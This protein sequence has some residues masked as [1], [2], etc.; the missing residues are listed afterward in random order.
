MAW[1]KS[2]RA[3]RQ[4]L[5]LVSDRLTIRSGSRSRCLR[6]AR[7][8]ATAI[9][10]FVVF[11]PIASTP[12]DDP[13][14][15]LLCHQYRGL[16]RYDRL[17]DRVHLFFADPDL[18]TGR[19]GPHARLACTDCHARRE[20]SV[21]PHLAVTPVDCA[22]Q[23]HLSGPARLAREFSH[24]NIV[25]ML[26]GSSH[27]PD[28]LAAIQ[29]EGG[30]VLSEGQSICLYCHDEPVF[31]DASNLVP[32][33]GASADRALDRCN[34]CHGEKVPADI[35]Y[36]LRH[37]SSRLQPARSPLELAQVCAVCHSDPRVLRE[38][39]LSNSVA[40]F[41]RSFHGKA[42]LLGDE[43]TADCLSCHVA[44]GT[45]VHLMLGRDDPGSSVHV[46]R[47]ANSCRSVACHPGADKAIADVAVHLDLPSALGTFEFALAAL[48]IVLTVLTFGPSASLVLLDLFQVLVGSHNHGE[49]GKRRLV[50]RIERHPLGRGRLIRFS[51]KQ[52]F[53]HWILAVSFTTLVLTGFP[54][55]FADTGWAA[56]IISTLGGLHVARTVHQR[57]DISR[58]IEGAQRRRIQKTR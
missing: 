54:M 28:V 39:D 37:I 14:N 13:D 38:H 51:V 53:E 24:D 35:E 41:V 16:A 9:A 26:A 8:M 3:V 12:G 49:A 31:R 23:C 17:T 30:P 55:K 20:V 29:F 32:A 21:V 5:G 6:R 36:Y 42:A 40:S 11:G 4:L 33:T 44:A 43:T 10:G 48:F 1:R 22:R 56:F 2:D 27:S 25:G 18:A 15:C 47:I 46:D 34:V 50:Q 19:N 7:L 57:G 58:E 52:R 45:N